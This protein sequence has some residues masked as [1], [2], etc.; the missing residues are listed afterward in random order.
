MI[1]LDL[2]DIIQFSKKDSQYSKHV[3]K[4]SS[5]SRNKNKQYTHEKYTRN[6]DLVKHFRKLQNK[7]N[8]II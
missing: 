1:F 8:N 2:I 5:S 4:K 7:V 3:K 6:E